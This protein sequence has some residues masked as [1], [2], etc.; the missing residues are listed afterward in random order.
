MIL[1]GVDLGLDLILNLVQDWGS[2]L[3]RVTLQ[4]SLNV[5]QFGCKVVGLSW[6]DGSRID[7]G[8]F[9]DGSRIGASAGGDGCVQTFDS[10]W[11]G[12]VPLH[13][14]WV[15]NVTLNVDRVG[16]VDPLDDSADD[17]DMTDYFNGLFNFHSTDN[18][19]FFNHF[20]ITDHGHFLDDLHGFNN[21]HGLLNDP[22]RGFF[23]G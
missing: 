10:H 5:V 13:M 18:G 21:L 2:L 17:R 14:D 3:D 23:M 9:W 12:N 11:H 1:L 16:N 6:D 15:R 19:H 20:H 4:E 22:G 7:R 8:W